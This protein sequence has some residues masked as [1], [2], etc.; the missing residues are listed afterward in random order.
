MTAPFRLANEVE[1]TG[2]GDAGMLPGDLDGDGELEDVFFQARDCRIPRMSA[3]GYRD[4]LPILTPSPWTGTEPDRPWAGAYGR[5]KVDANDANGEPPLD[6]HFLWDIWESW[7]QV[8][9]EPDPAKRDEL[10]YQILDVW[11]EQIPIVGYLGQSPALVIMKNGMS[12]YF[13][14]Q[15]VNDGLA[16]EHFL[17]PQL[18][19]WDNSEDHM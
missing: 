9:S 10:V 12:N 17:Y 11:A 3:G 16:D 1:T 14:G 6:G 13:N 2:F 15:P 18:L 8:S 7:D 19:A 5:W 4:L